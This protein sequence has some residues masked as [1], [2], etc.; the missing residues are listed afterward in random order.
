MA[1]SYAKSLRK[2]IGISSFTT[3]NLN[4]KQ[5]IYF[6]VIYEDAKT[7]KI[8]DFEK[9]QIKRLSDRKK[10]IG[11]DQVLVVREVQNSKGRFYYK[12]FNADGREAEQ[13]GNG[14]RCVKK[15]L[16]DRGFWKG[17]NLTLVAMKSEFFVQSENNKDFVVGL[18]ALG[19]SPEDVGFASE[20]SEERRKGE[21]SFYEVKL[22]NEFSIN[23]C[24]VSMGNPHG[25]C[26]DDLNEETQLKETFERL[27]TKK[28]FRN[29]INLE[30]CRKQ[31]D[32][33]ISLRVLRGEW[34][35]LTHVGVVL[36]RL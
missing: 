36:A 35:R 23:L 21:K 25:V 30:F 34:E 1:R 8:F 11:A 20:I 27:N 18:K 3:I 17:N 32:T 24:F 12:I 26:W 28:F 33:A 31:T 13:C 6:I 15:F 22:S 29:G 7:S 19:T 16:F 9:S 14:A 5:T 2:I 4:K 10:G